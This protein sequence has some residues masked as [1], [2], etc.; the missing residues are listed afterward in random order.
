LFAAIERYY[1]A[2]REWEVRLKAF[3][4]ISLVKPRPRGWKAKKRANSEAGNR[5]WKAEQEVVAIRAKTVDGLIAKSRASKTKFYGSDDIAAS[6][7]AD[8]L[9]MTPSREVIALASKLPVADDDLIVLGRKFEPLVDRYYLAQRRWSRSLAAAHAEHDQEFGDPAD[10]NYEYPPEIVAAF[11][12]SCERSGANEADDAL[13]AIHEEMKEVA[14]AIN[15]ASVTS[16]EGLRAKALVAFWEVAP[17]VAGD[18]EFSFDGAYPFQQLFTAVAEACG[19][20][21]KIAAT[22]Y[23]LPKLEMDEDQEDVEEDCEEA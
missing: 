21:K 5:A 17:L 15:A 18:T 7:A 12:D 16:I 2:C 22:G 23:K 1:E 14:N 13:S 6:I 3:D 19:L 20:E 11:S 4:V 9:T 10:R 8:L